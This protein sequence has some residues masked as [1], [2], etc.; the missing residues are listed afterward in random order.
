MLTRNSSMTQP[1]A[2]SLGF[3]LVIALYT[4]GAFAMLALLAAS[5]ATPSTPAEATSNTLRAVFAVG[6]VVNAAIAF[7]CVRRARRVR[8]LALVV[9]GLATTIA[10][11]GVASALFGSPLFDGGLGELCAKF[12]VHALALWLWLSPWMRRQ[13]AA[14]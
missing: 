2:Y 14:E 9:H 8:V 10:L 13:F 12:A 4:F 7:G 5:F 3:K 11:A 1:R 6:A